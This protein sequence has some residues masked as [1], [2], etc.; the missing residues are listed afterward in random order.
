MRYGLNA[1]NVIN[2]VKT[3]FKE[4]APSLPPGVRLSQAT[5]A[6]G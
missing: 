6:R 1:L 5:I 4:L 3:K 2:G